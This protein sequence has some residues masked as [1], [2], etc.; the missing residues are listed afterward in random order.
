MRIG[1]DERM[2]G[3]GADRQTGGE[4]ADARRTGGRHAK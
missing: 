1:A 2:G 4:W 3:W